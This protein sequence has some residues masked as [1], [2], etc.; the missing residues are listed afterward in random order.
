MLDAKTGAVLALATR[1][2]VDARAPRSPGSTLKPFVIAAAL[3]AGVVEPGDRLDCENGARAYGAKVVTDA[4]PHGALDVGGV[5][6]VSSNVCTAKLAEPLGDRLGAA[7]RRYRFAAPPRTDTRSF[8]GA[9]ISIGHGLHASPL[10]LA[11]AYTAFA[12]GGL[13]HAPHGSAGRGERVMP[14]A[15]AR[16]VLAMLDRVVNDAGGTGRAARIPGVRV[17]GKTGTAASGT[18]GRHYASFV[19]IAPADAPRVIV[20]VGLDGVRGAGGQVAA[21]VFARLAARALRR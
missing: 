12:D 11:A 18:A 20:L 5:L 19:G 16:A 6:A 9:A 10:D 8:E 13:Y 7:L 2:D 15:T 21:P 14:E 3:E 4:S 17:A 1:G